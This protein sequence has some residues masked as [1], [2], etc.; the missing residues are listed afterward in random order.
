[1]F[2]FHD[3][4]R[5]YG[6]YSSNGRMRFTRFDGPD[7]YAWQVLS[8]VRSKAYRPGDWNRLKIRLEPG[9]ITGY[10]N[11]VLVVESTDDQFAEGAAGLASFRETQAEF[12]GFEI[13]KN[14]AS[15]L[16]S[17]ELIE[18][19]DRTVAGLNVEDPVDSKTIDLF[20]P[21]RSAGVTALR[22]R[23]DRREREARQLRSLAS[24]IEQRQIQ[25]D[26][27]AVFK[28]KAEKDID[29]LRAALLVARADNA[30]IDVEAYQRE[31]EQMAA[32]VRAD[33]PKN[34]DTQTKLRAIDDTLFKKLGFHGSRTDF[35]NRSNSY[36]NE[37]ID[38]REGLPITLAVLY[39][40][41]ARRVGVSVSGVGSP[42]RFLVRVE[43]A[44]ASWAFID[45][46]DNA[47][48]LSQKEAEALA[49]S[50]AGRAI[51]EDDLR[52]QTKK[53]IVQRLV[54]NLV[55]IAQD[56]N[57]SEGMLRYVELLLILDPD[58]L[59]ERWRRAVL[60]YQTGRRTESLA[61]TNWLLAKEPNKLADVAD[62]VQVRQLKALL[63]SLH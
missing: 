24:A 59:G 21:D 58:S 16:P 62:P 13:G 33:L 50:M 9:K 20:L 2:Q 40:E 61:E 22:E 53:Q 5:H 12:K 8:E 25:R 49:A 23:A 17:R 55:N 32:S 10:V 57:D 14:L 27:D 36:L 29:L 15:S 41:M 6:F 51:T 3:G 30:E 38:D 34:A 60:C 63:E 11:E 4:D 19:V 54:S 47:K 1:M 26:L 39:I 56:A 44:P 37:V 52:L 18:R 43:G 48:R 35:Y 7:V 45:V 46:F 42:G 31:V 28:G